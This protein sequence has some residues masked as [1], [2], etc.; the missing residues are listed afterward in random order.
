V[1]AH[2]HAQTGEEVLRAL[3]V[4]I[5][6]LGPEEVQARMQR[7]GPN[8][9]PTVQ[10]PGWLRIVMR[11]FKSPLIYILLVAAA[12]STAL[13]DLADAGFICLVLILNATIGAI[14]ESRAESSARALRSLVAPRAHVLREGEELEID[15]E[16][17]VPGD[18]VVLESGMKVPADLRLLSGGLQ[19][20]ESLLTGESIAVSTWPRRWPIE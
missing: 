5:E 18:V 12:V 3:E 7:Y 16:A 14:Q 8:A 15:A 11:Q 19:I 4:T 13:G 10:P 6:G 9:L 17:I 1:A 2:A 20:D